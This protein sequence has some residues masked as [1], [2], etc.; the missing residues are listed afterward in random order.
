MP[1]KEIK[2]E[3]ESPGFVSGNVVWAKRTGSPAWP[4]L[5]TGR[6]ESGKGACSRYYCTFLASNC[7]WTLVKATHL[8]RFTT[9]RS[10]VC[11]EKDGE[12]AT[13]FPS[14]LGKED[15]QKLH[16]AV[17]LGES[18]LLDP[19]NFLEYLVPKADEEN[20]HEEDESRND[21]DGRKPGEREGSLGSSASE[22]K[23]PDKFKLEGVNPSSKGESDPLEE[24]KP[25]SSRKLKR[26]GDTLSVK[27]HATNPDEPQV[28]LPIPNDCRNHWDD[29]ESAEATNEN[30]SSEAPD[31]P[32]NSKY[33]KESVGN[34]DHKSLS[35]E[36]EHGIEKLIE[37]YADDA[38]QQKVDDI[39][40]VR[41]VIASRNMD[42]K[43][44]VNNIV[45]EM[46]D[47]VK[48]GE[49]QQQDKLVAFSESNDRLEGSV[50]EGGVSQEEL[51][52]IKELV[53]QL[54]REEKEDREDR[55][56]QQPDQEDTVAQMDVEDG[57]RDILVSTSKAFISASK[58]QATEKCTRCKDKFSA[59][60]FRRHQTLPHNFECNVK[61]CDC[62]C[63]DP[64]TLKKHKKEVHF[65]GCLQQDIQYK[66]ET[67]EEV[68]AP[69]PQFTK[70][71]ETAHCF[72]CN[73]CDLKYVEEAKLRKHEWNHHRGK[74]KRKSN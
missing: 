59:D 49:Q 51:M 74:E 33:E 39:K 5:V 47:Q 63:V 35:E 38:T 37:Y 13:G 43:V 48:I 58:K 25:K 53:A 36:S 11:N 24:P 1:R 62:V 32:K 50:S 3:R 22:Q 41:I 69:G 34:D 67:C 30:N 28:K 26:K 17:Q 31:K 70:H 65:I 12:W 54:D 23:C 19:E 8:H 55:L 56:T 7:D 27:D 2:E 29:F 16:T 10:M 45:E 57:S 6:E 64:L 4:A 72:A 71:I 42:V 40:D 52:F 15:K 60:S 44:V 21:Q 66:C 61:G 20:N 46:E 9:H 73:H 68:M 18:I 14:E